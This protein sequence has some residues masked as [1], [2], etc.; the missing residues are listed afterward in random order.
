MPWQD[1][2]FFYFATFY[3]IEFIVK[4]VLHFISG[5]MQNWL[6]LARLAVEAEFPADSVLNAMSVFPSRAKPFEANIRLRQRDTYSGL[7]KY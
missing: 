1:S 5:R 6:K 4:D 3:L 7:R 2:T